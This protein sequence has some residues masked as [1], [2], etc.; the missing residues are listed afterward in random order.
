MNQEQLEVYKG[1]IYQAILTLSDI[2]KKAR[3]EYT[4]GDIS[5]G[6]LDAIAKASCDAITA[7]SKLDPTSLKYRNN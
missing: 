4:S 2:I 5:S 7:L 1:T 6:E 3:E